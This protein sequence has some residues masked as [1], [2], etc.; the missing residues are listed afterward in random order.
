[1]ARRPVVA[2]NWKMHKSLGETRDFLRAFLPMVAGARDREILVAPP[3]TA[4]ALAAELVRGSNVAIAAQNMHPEEKGAFT[5]EVSP[6]MLSDLGVRWVIV[7]HSER[8]H[9]FGE[10]DDFVA[11]K[12]RSA[13]DHG[14]R[15]ILCIGETLEERDAGATLSVLER[16]L[17]AALAGIPGPDLAGLVVAYEPV[18]AIGTGRTATTAQVQEAHRSVRE[19]FAGAFDSSIAGEIRILY[20]GS[21]KPGNVDALMALD[22]VDGVL[23]GGASLEADSFSRIVNFRPAG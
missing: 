20:G 7:G 8:R 11:A 4:L 6:I 1:M 19:W 17:A 5:G 23:V 3:F 2:A 14:L 21:V 9:V 13:L 15:P 16:Q 10:G 12:V 22:D 18:W